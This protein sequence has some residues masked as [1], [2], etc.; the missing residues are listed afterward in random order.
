M[1]TGEYQFA[2]VPVHKIS[3]GRRDAL[4]N[5]EIGFVFQHFHLI[6]NAFSHKL[7]AVIHFDRLKG[8][9]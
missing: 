2:G 6:P 8:L 1:D 9:E 3:K 5:N 7:M 4:R